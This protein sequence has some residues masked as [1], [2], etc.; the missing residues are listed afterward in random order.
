MAESISDAQ[1]KGLRVRDLLTIIICTASIVG[2]VMGGILTLKNDIK[3]II[4]DRSYETRINES[5]FL[6]IEASLKTVQSQVESN[7]NAININS[8]QIELLKKYILH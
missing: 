2:S 7:K 8:L 6:I 5:R 1:I 4:K 3:I